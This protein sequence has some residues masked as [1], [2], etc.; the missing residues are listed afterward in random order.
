MYDL[1][2]KARLTSTGAEAQ[3][4]PFRFTDEQDAIQTFEAAKQA[5][6]DSL[7]EGEERSLTLTDPEGNII[8]EWDSAE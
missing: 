5:G 8:R 3:L 2:F 4:P 1:T 7:V 6:I